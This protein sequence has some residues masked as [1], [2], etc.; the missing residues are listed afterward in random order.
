[1]EAREPVPPTITA[2]GPGVLLGVVVAVVLAF[3]VG[4]VVPY[5]VNDLER[6]SLSDITSGRYDPKEMWP[7]TA[8]RWAVPLRLAGAF[9]ATAGMAGVLLA[10]AGALIGL[11]ARWRL[12][13]AARRTCVTVV[14]V[15]GLTFAVMASAWGRALAVWI[16]D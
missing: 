7:A 6:L 8:G 4:V 3:G 1:M 10:M 9:A 13:T 2:R 12:S 5:F 14:I 16:L 11:A 15:G